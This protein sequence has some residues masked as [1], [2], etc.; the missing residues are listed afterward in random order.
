MKYYPI[1]CYFL[2]VNSLLSAQSIK[3]DTIKNEIEDALDIIKPNT[4][5]THPLGVY[6]SRINHNFD[7]R[8]SKKSSF[9]FEI[10][11]GNVFLPFVK[12]YE[13]TNL[14]DQKIAESLPW[15]NRE[16]QFNLNEVPSKTK[17][18]SADGVI[19]TYNF[20]FSLPI[21]SYHELSFGV[22]SFSLDS[23]KFPFSIITSDKNIEWF[24]SNIAGGKDP[25]SRLYYGYD[26]AGILYKDENNNYIKMNAGNFK[27]AGIELNYFYYPK[28][29]INQKHN[30]YLNYGAH[31]GIN[32]SRYNPVVDM[33][34][35]SSVIKKIVFRNK[36][37]MTFGLSAGALRQGIIQFGD[38]VNISNQPFLYS[39]EGLF[40]YKKKLKNNNYFSYGINYTIQTSYIKKKDFD[41]VV[42][43]GERIKTH[44]QQTIYH[45]YQ[46]LHGTNIIFTYSDKKIT[47]FVYLREDFKLD[48]APDLQSGIGIKMALKN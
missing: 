22:R 20:T 3:K 21:N 45:L 31:L 43:T 42:L 47:Y 30:L 11:S 46:S 32:T 1:L 36:N 40:N 14:T 23:G 41:Y 2:V 18:F 35:S 37:T 34:V 9:T 15:Y 28:L 38:K 5:S 24:H 12:S 13:L 4:L 26:K 6:I 16:F 25:F 33:G 8:S 29:K 10:S 19:R 39:L 44:W 48:N 17:E 7:I 27:I